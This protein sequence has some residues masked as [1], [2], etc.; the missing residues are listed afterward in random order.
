VVSKKYALGDTVLEGVEK[1]AREAKY[2]L[3]ADRRLVPP[4]EWRKRSRTNL[5]TPTHRSI[6]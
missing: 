2:D 3:W 1:D 5:A 6:A 4:W